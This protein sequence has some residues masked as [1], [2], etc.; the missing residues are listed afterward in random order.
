M[1][2]YRKIPK[3]T[4]FSLIFILTITNCAN[5]FTNQSKG[6]GVTGHPKMAFPIENVHHPYNSVG[7][8]VIRMTHITETGTIID[9]IFWCQFFIPYASGMKTSGAKNK[10]G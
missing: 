5:F 6:F 10:H 1:E 3:P 4:V 2:H 7:T 9:S 8:T